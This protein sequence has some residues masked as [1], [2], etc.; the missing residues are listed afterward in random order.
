MLRGIYSVASAMEMAAR[1]QEI[2]S[3]NIVHATTPGYRRQGLV[4]EATAAGVSQTAGA[5]PAPV[6]KTARGATSYLYLDPGPLQQTN[7]SLDVA[8]HGDAFFVVQGP[9]GPLYTRNGS[10]ELGPG[11]K[12]QTRGGG[13]PVAGSG[14]NPISIPL[15]A[16][17]L[18]I[19]ADGTIYANGAQVARL[20]LANFGNA[21][22]LRRVGPT[23]YEGDNPQ[24]PA[25]GAARVE[26]GYR[27]GSNVQPVQEMVSMML[28]MRFYE[29]AGKTMQALSD[30]VSQNTRVQQA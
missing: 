22:S 21:N 6:P 15:D 29:A 9:N 23:L 20:Q 1:N 4:Y 13:Y 24:T 19:D 28:G 12:L 18:T 30:A 8:V 5:D 7:N 10:F 27:E 2:I 25:P 26:Q 16:G 17:N 14:G 3:E 11:N